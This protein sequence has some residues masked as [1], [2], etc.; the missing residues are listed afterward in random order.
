[1]TL[2]TCWYTWLWCHSCCLEFGAGEE[3]LAVTRDGIEEGGKGCGRHTHD[4]VGAAVVDIDRAV[5][6][7]RATGIDD[8]WLAVVLVVLVWHEDRHRRAVENLCGVAV[9][10][11][12]RAEL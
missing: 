8:A 5:S 2:W 4:L 1:M 6:N 3:G 11:Q 7:D 9:V 12:H 10:E